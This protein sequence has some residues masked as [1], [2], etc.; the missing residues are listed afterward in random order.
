MLAHSD[1]LCGAWL[2]ACMP[3]TLEWCFITSFVV[4]LAK[5]STCRMR[6]RTR[7]YLP[8]ALAYNSASSPEA[9]TRICHAQAARELRMVSSLHGRGLGVPFG[10]RETGMQESD[11]DKACEQPCRI[12]IGNRDLSNVS[13]LGRYFRTPGT[14]TRPTPERR[15]F[16]R[17]PVC[18]VIGRVGAGCLSRSSGLHA[19][20]DI[21]PA[22]IVVTGFS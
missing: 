11:L 10:L 1:C 12:P 5:A 14:E 9:M 16:G 8:C 19:R 3:G 7:S 17:R 21:L 18:C 6:K 15:K 4:L 2:C 22:N 13:R 20:S